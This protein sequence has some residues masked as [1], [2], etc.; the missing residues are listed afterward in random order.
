MRAGSR[1]RQR[2]RDGQERRNQRQ[3]ERV[4]NFEADKIAR[5]GT[6]LGQP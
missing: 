5:A 3:T 6:P 1:Q 4:G 2:Q